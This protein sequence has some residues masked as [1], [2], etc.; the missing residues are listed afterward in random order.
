MH[1]PHPGLKP[2]DGG[3]VALEHALAVLPP[4]EIAGRA[5]GLAALACT[6]PHWYSREQ[7]YALLA[8][9]K[10]LAERSDSRAAKYVNYVVQLYLQGGPDHEREALAAAEE[11]TRIHRDDPRPQTAVAPLYVAL[12]RAV[13]ALQ[14]GETAPLSGML[15]RAVVYAR[16]I[17]N[18]MV[19]HFE[20]FQALAH[21]NAGSWTEGLPSLLALH[22]RAEQN[23]VLGTEPFCAFDRLII[24]SELAERVIAMDDNLRS[25]LDFDASE[26]PSVWSMKVRALASAGLLEEAKAALRAVPPEALAKLP[27]DSQYLGTLGHLTHAALRLDALDYAQACYDL[28]SKYPTHF[29][30]NFA[31]LCDGAVPQLLGML[32]AALGRHDE[33]VGHFETG[34]AM[35]ERAGFVPRTAEAELRLA[36]YL[37]AH[38]DVAG[39]ERA[40]VL[41]KQA[42]RTAIRVGMRSMARSA[43]GLLKG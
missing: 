18:M 19:W 2:V 20:R 40:V 23:A 36:E 1:N 7:S 38:G 14:H 41:A 43:G 33:V 10:P 31:F 39:R 5:T 30:A 3:R 28:L 24:F 12:Y 21:I 17:R 15:E 42:Q 35:N 25:A 29:A 32:A 6:S 4:E 13:H 37:L 22:R 16:E 11:I 27:C 9:A 26:P 34:I 8:E